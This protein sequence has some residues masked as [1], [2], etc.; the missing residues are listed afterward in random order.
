MTTCHLVHGDQRILEAPPRPPPL[1]RGSTSC[2]PPRARPRRWRSSSPAQGQAQRHRAPRAHPQR[3]HRRPRR[4]RGEGRHR[5]EVNA[6]FKEAEEGPMK[7]VL[8]ITETPFVSVDFRC[9]DVSTTIDAALT[10]V[11]GD[12]MVKVVAW[13]DNEGATPSVWSTSRTSSPTPY[14][15][16]P[17][18]WTPWTPS[19]R[20]TR[21]PRSARSSIKR[22]PEIHRGVKSEDVFKERRV[23]RAKKVPTILFLL[24]LALIKK[25]TLQPPRGFREEDARRRVLINRRSTSR[26]EH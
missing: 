1:R 26:P 10:M 19:A 22:L 20:T 24:E 21:P 7:G 3:F 18:P 8:A 14:R 13:Y 4:Q 12:D 2:P 23:R 25:M 16:R 11:M 5:E 17:P 15:G 9:S 6:A